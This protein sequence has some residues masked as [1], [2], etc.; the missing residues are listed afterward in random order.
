MV[1]S[2][3]SLKFNLILACTLGLFVTAIS[4]VFLCNSLEFF[5]RVF[6]QAKN[7]STGA[8][9]ALRICSGIRT[10]VLPSAIE[11][12]KDLKRLF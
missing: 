11:K 2:N 12:V 1:N 5:M 7:S 9:L 4:F 6:Y 3:I 8:V 10:H